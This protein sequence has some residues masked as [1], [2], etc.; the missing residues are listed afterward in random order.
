[1][2]IN[3]YLISGLSSLP[4]ISK[5]EIDKKT[6]ERKGEELKKEEAQKSNQLIKPPKETEQTIDI[7]A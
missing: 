4:L 3:P 6:E 7:M 2:I 5:N 1:M